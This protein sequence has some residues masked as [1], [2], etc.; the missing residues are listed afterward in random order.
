MRKY[1]RMIIGIIAITSTCNA[2]NPIPYTF[3]VQG[4]IIGEKYT[5][6]QTRA[7]LGSNPLKMD[8]WDDGEVIGRDYQ[9]GVLNNANEFWFRSNNQD[10]FSG[11]SLVDSTFSVFEGHLKVGNKISCVT[12]L[13]GDLLELKNS[14][15]ENQRLYLFYPIGEV[16][17]ECLTI[18]TDINGIITS[19]WAEP[20]M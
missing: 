17:E 14:N 6:S 19:M 12:Q 15:S 20:P 8:T 9:Y 4:L 13:G 16:S 3:D 10:E 5:D 7:K 2:A 11:F 1:F 18:V